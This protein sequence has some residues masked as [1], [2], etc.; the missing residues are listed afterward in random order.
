MMADFNRSDESQEGAK[1]GPPAAVSAALAT[2]ARR[3]VPASDDWPDT[4]LH[5]E[6]GLGNNCMERMVSEV[7]PRAWEGVSKEGL[8]SPWYPLRCLGQRERPSLKCTRG[9]EEEM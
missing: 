7:S 2:S 9:R 3:V 1:W 6:E 4:P 5:M 8:E